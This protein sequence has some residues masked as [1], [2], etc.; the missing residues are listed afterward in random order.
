MTETLADLGEA[1]L[2]RRLA[3]FAHAGQFSDDTAC[4]RS[5]ER[6]LV[7]NT[8]VLVDGIHFSEQAVTAVGAAGSP[9]QML[10]SA[11]DQ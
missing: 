10:W 6:Q 2:L 8:D 3:G 5:D 7:V 9:G 1:E 11:I 4:L